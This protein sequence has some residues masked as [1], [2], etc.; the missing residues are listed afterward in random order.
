[1]PLPQAPRVG[2]ALSHHHDGLIAVLHRLIWLITPM[3]VDACEALLDP[4][5]LR[6]A[7]WRYE[8]CW[9]PLLLD[10]ASAPKQKHPLAPPLDVAWVWLV[11][12]LHPVSY[13]QVGCPPGGTCHI[14][15]GFRV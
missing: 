13:A 3:Q 10:W 15:V 4:G 11:H 9:V 7:V 5:V 14:C 1:M 8:H 12:L 6:R 2:S